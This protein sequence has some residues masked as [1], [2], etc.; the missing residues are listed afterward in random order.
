MIGAWIT[1][2]DLA[3]KGIAENPGRASSTLWYRAVL[4]N[5]KTGDIPVVYLE[6]RYRGGM[7][8][9]RCH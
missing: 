1:N 5:G 2:A 3:S 8:L 4:L 9:P 7:H 6:A